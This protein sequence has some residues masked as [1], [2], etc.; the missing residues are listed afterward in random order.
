VHRAL[1][2]ADGMFPVTL[3]RSSTPDLVRLTVA[4]IA[5]CVTITQACAHLAE[6]GRRGELMVCVRTLYEH[7][8]MLAWLLGDDGENRMLLWQRYCDEQTLKFDDEQARLGGENAVSADTRAAIAAATHKLGTAKMPGL[9]DRAAQ[10]DREWE[11]RL[12]LDPCH[13]SAWSLRHIYSFVFRAGS[14]MAHP[15]LAG[16]ELVTEKRTDEVTISIEAPGL[17]HEAL[18]PVPVL[19]GTTLAVSSS[20]FQRPGAHEINAHLDWLLTAMSEAN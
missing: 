7:T 6:L 14:A 15:T 8:V 11:E 12:G 3:R 1:A 2:L 5:R 4:L 17:A 19:I 9:P 18:L 16:L 20:V 10:A 13:R